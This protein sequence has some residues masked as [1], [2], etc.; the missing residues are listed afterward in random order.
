MTNTINKV[1]I[2][3]ASVFQE[4]GRWHW[5]IVDINGRNYSPSDGEQFKG[6]KQAEA[7]MSRAFDREDA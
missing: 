2:A 6:R 1:S 3:R 5:R 4:R 7:A